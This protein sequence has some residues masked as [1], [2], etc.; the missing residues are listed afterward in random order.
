MWSWSV[1]ATFS[2]PRCPHATSGREPTRKEAGRRV[3]ETY[4]K[5]CKF[6]AAHPWRGPSTAADEAADC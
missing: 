4:E 3:A 5:M 2:G 6:Y 1:T